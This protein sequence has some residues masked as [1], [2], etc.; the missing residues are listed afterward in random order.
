MQPQPMI[1]VNDVPGSSLWY[2]QLLNC[3]SGHGG[4]EYERLIG[5][6]DELIMQLHHWAAHEH[7]HMGDRE[8]PKGNGV[9]LWYCIDDFD[10]AVSRAQAMSAEILEGPMVNP[11]ANHREIWIRDPDG[12]VVVLASAPG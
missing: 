10:A 2:Q 1:A 6:A 8:L 7:P 4:D 3:R 11:N 12:Y 9:L 5:A